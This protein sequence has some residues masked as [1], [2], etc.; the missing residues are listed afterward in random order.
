VKE[1]KHKLLIE[2]AILE[3]LSRKT[4]EIMKKIE[5][6]EKNENKENPNLKN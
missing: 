4:D 5:N 2:L 3:F 6:E 1:I